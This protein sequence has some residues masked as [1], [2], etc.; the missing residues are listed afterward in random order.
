MS[1]VLKDLNLVI[2][3]EDLSEAERQEIIDWLKTKDYWDFDELITHIEVNYDVICQSKQSYYDLLAE[4]GVTWKKSQKV[5]PK[6]EPE[7][8]KKEEI[9]E[10]IEANQSE[11]ESGRLVVLCLDECH[12]GW[13]DVCGDM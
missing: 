11:I 1:E 12:L 9:R 3:V 10:F 7:V 13:G 4:A 2:G 5:N 6:S 8:V